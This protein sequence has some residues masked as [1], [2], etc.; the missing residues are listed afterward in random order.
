VLAVVNREDCDMV[1]ILGSIVASAD[2]YDELLAASLAHVRRS[3]GEPGC[4]SHAVAIDVENP[5]RLVFTERWAD[6]GA[7]D[8]HFA[9]PAVREFAATLARLGTTPELAIYDVA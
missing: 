8:A 4:L 9:V 3:R 2:S 6:R 7:V 5:L 1:I